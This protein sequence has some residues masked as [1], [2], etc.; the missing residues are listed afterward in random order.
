MDRKSASTRFVYEPSGRLQSGY[1][2]AFP[3]SA[4]FTNTYDALGRVKTQADALGNMWT[5]LFANGHRSEEIDPTGANRSLYFD[6]N[7]NHIEDIDQLQYHTVY[8]Y[9]GIGRRVQTNYPGGDK[10]VL[11][12]DA[13]HNVLSKT[14]YPLPGSIDVI[15]GQAPAPLVQAWT[16]DSTYNKPLTEKNARGYITTYVYDSIGRPI[17]VSQ[18]LVAKPGLNAATPVTR[19]AYNSR[20][21]VAQVIDPENRLTVNTYDVASGNLLSTVVDSGS[22]RLNLTTSNLYDGVGNLTRTVDPSGAY[23]T[24]TYDS[25]RRRTLETPSTAGVGRTQYTYDL[26]DRVLSVQRETGITAAPWSTTTSTY[27][28]N[29]KI[30]K[31]IGPD[32][33]GKTT[34]YDKAGRVA[35]EVS[36]SGRATAGCR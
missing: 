15:S 4:A 28:A 36:S 8:V 12:Y 9:D 7:G 26:D 21:Q 20:G 13:R 22:G 32:G 25:A 31:V 24:Y 30:I 6:A 23:I 19:Y 18:P 27:N 35:S 29:D 2:P 17:T 1:Y 34:N 11:A 3:N 5:Y 10:E 16:Y 14:S 33:I